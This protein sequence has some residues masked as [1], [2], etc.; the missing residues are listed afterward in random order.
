M[1]P[2]TSKVKARESTNLMSAS[3][4]QEIATTFQEKATLES[5]KLGAG[6]K[7]LS[8][9]LGEHFLEKKIKTNELVA[10]CA[11]VSVN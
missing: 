6:D 4:L 5:A 9:R 2:V 3:R 7:A 8:V 10:K 11:L 1:R